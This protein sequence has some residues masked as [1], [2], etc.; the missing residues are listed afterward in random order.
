[1]SPDKTGALVKEFTEGLKL[2][3]V[4]ETQA[5]ALGIQHSNQPSSSQRQ[6]MIE[7]GK[8]KC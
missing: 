4:D 2:Q 3:S 8:L 7:G 5:E 1:M 6:K